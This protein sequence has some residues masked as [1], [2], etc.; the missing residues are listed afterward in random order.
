M[1][2]VQEAGGVAGGFEHK[3]FLK[4]FKLLPTSVELIAVG[5][6]LCSI[7]GVGSCGNGSRSWGRGGGG[8]NAI[9]DSLGVY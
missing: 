7:V 3:L 2:G 1:L 9:H 6:C 5:D 4:R 8:S